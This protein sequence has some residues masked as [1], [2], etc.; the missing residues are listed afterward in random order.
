MKHNT[1]IEICDFRRS[2]LDRQ[3]RQLL[4]APVGNTKRDVENGLPGVLK[5]HMYLCRRGTMATD[6]LRSH[7]ITLC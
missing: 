4:G 7:G 5:S 1:M 6:K 2:N 3:F